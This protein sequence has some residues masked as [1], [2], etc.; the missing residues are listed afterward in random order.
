MSAVDVDREDEGGRVFAG[1]V[2]RKARHNAMEA[3]KK[4]VAKIKAERAADA[5]P[6]NSGGKPSNN[7]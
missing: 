5:G 3:V 1:R 7:S 4:T 6:N 2:L